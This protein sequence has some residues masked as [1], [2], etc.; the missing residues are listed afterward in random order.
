MKNLSNTEKK[1][2]KWLKINK[3]RLY[4]CVCKIL[5]LCVPSIQYGLKFRNIL[6]GEL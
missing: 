1:S 4:A 5:E 2:C 3:E 6:G